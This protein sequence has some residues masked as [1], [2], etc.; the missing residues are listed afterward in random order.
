MEVT[1]ELKMCMIRIHDVKFP[2][3]QLKYYVEK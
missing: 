2:K 1:E 3:D